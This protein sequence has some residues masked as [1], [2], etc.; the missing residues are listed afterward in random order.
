LIWFREHRP[1]L[2]QRLQY[3]VIEPSATRQKWQSTTVADFRDKVSWLPRITSRDCRASRIT[4]VIFANELLDA[5]PVR[6]FGWD[7]KGKKWFE[8]GVTSRNGE[9]AWTRLDCSRQREEA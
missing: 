7:A 2:F 5:M 1:E 8:W 3:F 6:R 4:G 9:L